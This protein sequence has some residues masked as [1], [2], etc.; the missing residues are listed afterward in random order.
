MPSSVGPGGGVLHRFEVGE[1]GGP[2]EGGVEVGFEAFEH[3]VA[4]LDGPGAGDEH[5]ERDEAACARLPGAEGVE[6]YSFIV[7]V[8]GEDRIN[9][10]AVGGG[11]G[12]VHQAT[13]RAEEKP[14]AGDDDVDSH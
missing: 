11:E 7:P 14:C 9:G 2:A 6:A 10:G 8:E 12:G 4:G 13:D 5:V 3:L 1:H